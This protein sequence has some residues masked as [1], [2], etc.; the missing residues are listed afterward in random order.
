MSLLPALAM[1]I[2]IPIAGWLGW[3]Q[4]KREQIKII[5]RMRKQN[6]NWRRKHR[7][8]ETPRLERR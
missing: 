3:N 8:Y 6:A 1:L 7:D 4:A 5:N 2:G